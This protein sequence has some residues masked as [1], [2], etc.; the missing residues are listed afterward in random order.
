LD[1]L[2]RYIADAC[3]ASPEFKAEYEAESALLALVR[4]RQAANLTQQ[5]VADALHVSQPYIVQIE[6]G[7]RAPG[8]RLL[9]RYAAAVGASIKIA[10]APTRAATPG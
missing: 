4:A 1:D 7:T 3:A 6:R 8:Y 9:F 2:D 10:P 5:D